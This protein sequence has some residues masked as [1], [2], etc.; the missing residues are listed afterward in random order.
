[1]RCMSKWYKHMARKIEER[2]FFYQKVNLRVKV[3]T[4]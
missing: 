1:M 4:F 3:Y 2:G